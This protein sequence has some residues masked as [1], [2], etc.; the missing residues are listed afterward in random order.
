MKKKLPSEK[1]LQSRIFNWLKIIGMLV[2][3]LAGITTLIDWWFDHFLYNRFFTTPELVI[4]QRLSPEAMK[5]L[6]KGNKITIE[7]GIRLNNG[8]N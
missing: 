1:I 3:V 2:A 6:K 5:E 7:K 4:E 8:Q